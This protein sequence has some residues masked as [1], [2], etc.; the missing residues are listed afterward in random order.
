MLT[1]GW[2]VCLFIDCVYMYSAIDTAT[3]MYNIAAKGPIIT[4][5]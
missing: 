1:L 3:C 4:A 2:N 5:S